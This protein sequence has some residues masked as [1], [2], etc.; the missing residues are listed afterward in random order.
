[1]THKGNI[2]LFIHYGGDWLRGSEISLFKILK[3]LDREMFAPFLICNREPFAQEVRKTGV[4]V[5]TM[6]I[7]GIICARYLL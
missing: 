1:M 5:F 3:G 2:A 7:P 6:D 4:Q